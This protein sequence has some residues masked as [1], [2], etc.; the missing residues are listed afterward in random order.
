MFGEVFYDK[1]CKSCDKSEA[2]F[3]EFCASSTQVFS[4]IECQLVAYQNVKLHKG[5]AI[6]RVR[7]GL[8]LE[9]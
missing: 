3:K 4:V 1:K 2:N 7:V 8:G 5:K 9:L 6:V